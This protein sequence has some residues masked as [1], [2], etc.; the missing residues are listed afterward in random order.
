M[1]REARD[2]REGAIRSSG[3][4]APKTSNF[5]PSPSRSSSLLAPLSC[6]VSQSCRPSKF[7]CAEMV[8]P[9]PASDPAQPFLILSSNISEQSSPPK[10][11]AARGESQQFPNVHFVHITPRCVL[12]HCCRFP[13]A[14]RTLVETY[15]GTDL[16]TL[17]ASMKVVLCTGM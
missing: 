2:M 11:C 16:E 10:N 8:F 7:C 6:A 3:F 15:P 14:I 4:E 9:Q 1:M 13:Y 17:Q 5:E 12:W